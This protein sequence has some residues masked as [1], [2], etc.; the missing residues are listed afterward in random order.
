VGVG[1][2]ATVAGAF[3]TWCAAPRAQAVGTPLTRDEV[4]ELASRCVEYS[5]HARGKPKL[6]IAVVDAEGN[7]L[8]VF[9]MTGLATDQFGT[10]DDAVA[11]ALAKA[12]TASYFSS[13]GETFTTRTA[14]FIIQD[15][16]PPGVRF[17]PGGPLYGV[18]FSSFATTDVNRVFYPPFPGS[19][20]NVDPLSVAETRVRGDLGGIA[21]YKNGKKVGALG[22]DDG[23]LSKRVSIPDSVFPG[24]DC[25]AGYRL[26][27]KNFERGRVLE[28]I[29]LAAARGFVAPAPI[30][31][32]RIL[33]GGIR[34][35]FVRGT[36]LRK[37][38]ARTLSID[39]DPDGDWDPNFPLTDG[40]PIDS[41]F[42]NA[43]IDPP[44]DA[45][46]GSRG[47]DGQIPVGRPIDAAADG[48]LTADDVKRILWQGAQ[49]ADI[50]RAAIRRPIGV[51]MQCWVSVV[52]KNGVLLGVFR[53]GRDATL[54][55][56][57]VAVQKARTAVLF[58]DDKAAFSSR[59]VG[60][61]AQAFYPAG[62]QSAARGPLYE[63]QDGITVGLLG[64]AFSKDDGEG[65]AT[66]PDGR[67]VNGITIF[68]GGVPLYKDGVLVGG[69]GVSGD[70]VD[71]DDIVADYASRGFGAPTAIRCDAMGAA[72]LRAALLRAL[73]RIDAVAPAD[74]GA[75][76]TLGN[77]VASFFRARYAAAR[78]ALAVTNLDV[79][80]PYV[81]HPRHPGP[82]TIR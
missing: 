31:A 43:T 41:R 63:L 51:V 78:E 17:Q 47:F 25:K 44:A 23:D 5:K 16:F 30:R 11:A 45:P 15:H 28:E 18:E 65:G 26:T 52:D 24:A 40:D 3:A 13:D 48:S 6:A 22:V 34:F 19:R 72:T 2:A 71:Q 69:V 21:L 64:G 56:Y 54:F 36:P 53:A 10:V 39:E 61:F 1:V 66:P 20:V 75:C 35:P 9:R 62:Q 68:P 27:F 80:P 33:V 29:A 70:G 7:S 67:L 38:A 50:T 79:A 76:D 73:D 46:A 55:S 8:G 42:A 14:A 74:P 59:A 82:V 4:V 12:G 57:D 60:L 81:K 77:K 49:R 32:D 58:S 37:R